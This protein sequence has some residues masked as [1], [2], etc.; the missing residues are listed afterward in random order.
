MSGL[1]PDPMSPVA[2]RVAGVRRET[3]DTYTLQLLPAAGN[4]PFRFAPGQFNMLYAFGIGEVPISMSGDPAEPEQL[5]H[6]VRAVGSVTNALCRARRGDVLGIRGPYGRP[7]PVAEVRGADVLVIAGGLGLA[8]LRPVVY[9][10][11]RHRA[12]YGHVA[13]LVGGRTP[14][15]LLF[16]GELARWAKRRDLLVLVTVDRASPGWAGRAGVVTALVAAAGF[17]AARTVAFV[18]GPEVM[19]RFAAR[20]LERH[21]IPDE[22]IY[23]SLERNM[24]C[25]V[26]FCGHCQLGPTFVCKD[27]PVLRYDRIRTLMALREI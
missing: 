6:T 9:Y 13:V 1:Q 25:A 8:P 24:K 26:G 20:E 17:H 14:G 18:C 2:F 5:V 12:E 11:L 19:M 27:G 23:C 3:A 10:L 21:G 15:D 4:A 7:W 16:R 22:R